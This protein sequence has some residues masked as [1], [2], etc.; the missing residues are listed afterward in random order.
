M[1]SQR[2]KLFCKETKKSSILAFF[3][4]SLQAKT[5][6][7][8]EIIETYRLTGIIIGMITFLIIG[9]FPSVGCEI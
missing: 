8:A 9:D 3:F 2:Y 6:K 1:V 7:M 4:V 5:K